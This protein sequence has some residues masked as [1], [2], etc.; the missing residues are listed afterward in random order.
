VTAP[1]R[2]SGSGADLEITERGKTNEATALAAIS[3][4]T[5]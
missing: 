1:N 4:N 3:A 2:Q 5:G